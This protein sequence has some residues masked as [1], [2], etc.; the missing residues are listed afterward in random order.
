MKEFF[1]EMITLALI[2]ILVI[3]ISIISSMWNLSSGSDIG[4]LYYTK[5]TGLK[6]FI[7]LIKL[8]FSKNKG[9]SH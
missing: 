6:K 9:Y 1:M 8:G 3:V 5:S 2:I 4:D 7:F